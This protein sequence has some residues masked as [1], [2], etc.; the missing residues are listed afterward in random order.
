L[1]LSTKIQNPGRYQG[2]ALYDK[3]ATSL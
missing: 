1:S 2:F 3:P